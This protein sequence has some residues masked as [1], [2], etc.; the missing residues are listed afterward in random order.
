MLW[1]FTTLFLLKSNSASSNSLNIT[2]TLPLPLLCITKMNCSKVQ[3][4]PP[5]RLH[6][7]VF[8]IQETCETELQNLSSNSH[9]IP[10]FPFFNN[11]YTGPQKNSGMNFTCEYTSPMDFE[12]LNP[13]L[14]S[15]FPLD[16]PVFP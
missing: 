6:I 16:P 12:P 7:T 3:K 2:T 10:L 13:N 15:E 8:N 4:F 1:T 14:V 5:C 11:K 9:T